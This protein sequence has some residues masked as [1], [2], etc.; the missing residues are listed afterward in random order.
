MV[1]FHTHIL[2]CVDD[3]S[4]SIEESLRML[5]EEAKQGV[6]EVILT[7]HFYAFKNSPNQFLAKRQAA[8]E[9]LSPYLT[10]DLPK[11][12]LGAEVL[13]FDGISS[14]DRLENLCIQGSDFLL[15]E[16]PICRWTQRM[17]EDILDINDRSDIRVVLAHVERYI[18]LQPKDTVQLLLR[19]GVLFQSNV[20]FFSEWGS[21]FK[22]MSM[23]KKGQIHIIGSDCHNLNKRAPNWDKLP[24]QV[25]IRAKEADPF[26]GR[27]I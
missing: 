2:P 15:L 21:R 22:A 12:R 16:M 3:G 27:Y 20:S 23:L 26:V 19:E 6:T 17:L 24:K 8:W 13:Y 1:D 4:Q 9:A 5:R 7:P 18:Y 11:I 14:V 10:D 25:F